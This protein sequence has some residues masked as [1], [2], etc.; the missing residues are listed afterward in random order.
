MQIRTN[1]IKIKK[2]K[3]TKILTSWPPFTAPWTSGTQ[4]IEKKIDTKGEGNSGKLKKK[5][6][7]AKDTKFREN[8]AGT[9]NW[10]PSSK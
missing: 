7:N 4:R 10:R 8:E 3:G 6:K 2:K 5:K 9:K 1:C